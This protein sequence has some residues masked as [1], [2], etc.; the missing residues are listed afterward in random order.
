VK[1]RRAAASAL[2]IGAVLTGSVP[3]VH[4]ALAAS[5]GSPPAVTV[6]A[7]A[8]RRWVGAW[9]AAAQGSSAGLADKRSTS[10]PTSFD[11]QTLSMIVTPSVG[12]SAIRI[13]MSNRFGQAPIAID[14]V[15]VG[16]RAAGAGVVPGSTVPVPF[17]GST[18]LVVPAGDEAVSDPVTFHVVASTE[19][20]VSFHVA[21]KSALD[22][23][24]PALMADYASARGTLSNENVGNGGASALTASYGV[25]SVDVLA[26]ASTRVVVTLGDSITDGIGS[27][28]DANRRW[29]DQ[30]A[31]L[32]D[33]ASVV[34]AAISGNRVA[35]NAEPSSKAIGPAA[36]NRVATDVLA[37][38][39]VTDLLVFEGINDITGAQ[40]PGDAVSEVIAGYRSIVSQAH[41]AGV[42]V[43]GATITP[44][45][46]TEQ[47]ESARLLINEWIRTSGGFD[48]V[49]DFDAAVR[50]LARP[51]MVRTA[52]DAYFAHLT[53]AGYAAL[54]HAISPG[55]FAGSRCRA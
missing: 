43:I 55:L 34:N 6:D 51:S 47:G 40:V 50:D 8:A 2:F 54:A 31:R 42:R 4:E 41:A 33:G 16:V 10:A 15:T 49:V 5:S 26:A 7:C 44:G 3:V 28:P 21:G 38:P 39:G 18:S 53:D 46:L 30:L 14:T 32:L 48:G 1:G 24:Q 17:G 12:G 37:V 20:N 29:P 25:T 19:L 9:M 36:R 13:H 35:R 45:G 22:V 11:D 27:T 23:H 52:F